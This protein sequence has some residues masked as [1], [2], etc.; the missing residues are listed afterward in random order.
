MNSYVLLFLR[1][2]EMVNGNKTST[3]KNDAIANYRIVTNGINL[4]K[5][6]LDKY[7]SRDYDSE[8]NIT[9]YRT[10]NPLLTQSL[11]TREKKILSKFD[12][13]LK[14]GAITQS[15]YEISL[16]AYN[17]FVLHII[18]YR[19]YGKNPLS[20]ERAMSAMRIFI[21]TYKKQMIEPTI[22]PILSDELQKK[23]EE[24]TGL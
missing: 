9:L 1:V 6:F 14:S 11:A 3:V 8:K 5:N 24:Y 19:D 10:K 21:A 4:A 15:E 16:Q 18:L 17:D 20:K 12:A 2:Q 23:Q 7:V 13:L 22:E